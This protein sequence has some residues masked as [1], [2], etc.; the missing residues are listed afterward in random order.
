MISD[1]KGKNV[2]YSPY[3]CMCGFFVVTLQTE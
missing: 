1:A 2:F 3:I